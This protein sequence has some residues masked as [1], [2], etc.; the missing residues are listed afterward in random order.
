MDAKDRLGNEGNVH[1]IT[2]TKGVIRVGNQKGVAQGD[3]YHFLLRISWP[4]FVALIALFYLLVSSL[5]ALA[6][7]LEI[8]SIANARPG[9]FLD[10]FFYSVDIMS[11]VGYSD[12]HPHTL[13]AK[14][15]GVGQAIIGLLSVAVVTGLTF[16]RFSKPKARI[17][18]SRV[19]VVA[20]FN[21]IPTLM[22]RVANQRS[23]MILEAQA[24]VGL[25]QNEI[26]LEGQFVRRLHDLPL[27]RHQS[28][29]FNLSWTIMHPIDEHSPFHKMPIETLREKAT[30]LAVI[31]TGTDEVMDQVIH[32]RYSYFMDD[33]KWD[34]DFVDILSWS[35]DGQI[36]VD[37]TKFHQV[38]PVPTYR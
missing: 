21:G 11:T 31:L 25:V 17:M 5:F 14:I 22:F 32:T 35:E 7:L 6:Y 36:T 27:A 37:Y 30:E 29:M 1:P 26:T 3:I 23:N 34:M 20:P 9:S 10:A 33:I 19:A 24:R 15:I 2:E 13:Y 18:F 8:D 4:Q 28:P 38:I 16:A 12:L